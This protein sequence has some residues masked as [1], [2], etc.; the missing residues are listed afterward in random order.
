MSNDHVSNNIVQESIARRIINLWGLKDDFCNLRCVDHIR[1]LD[2][3][4]RSNEFYVD[5][6]YDHCGDFLDGFLLQSVGSNSRLIPNDHVSKQ[7]R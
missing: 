7:S 4:L 6:G 2:W 1:I 5:R 3:V